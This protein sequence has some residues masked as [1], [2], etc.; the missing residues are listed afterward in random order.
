MI[1]VKQMTTVYSSG[2]GVFDVNFKVNKGEVIG[3]LGPNGAGKTTTIRSLLGFLKPKLGSALINDQNAWD[4]PTI[5]NKQIG[6]IPGEITFIDGMTGFEHLQLMLDLHKNNNK[7]RMNELLEKFEL[8]PQGK[9][10]RYSKGMK[11]K[12]ALV[13]AF[14]HDPD[15]LILDEPTSGLDPLMQKRFIDLIKEEK[16]KGKTI[17]ISSHQFEEVEKTC[18][19]VI[20]IK[21]GKIIE[22][23]DKK[24]L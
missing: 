13:S 20:I 8:N 10:R 9:I 21:E 17:L 18:D 22:I 5:T 12:L 2:K 4:N 19:E 15:I 6:Y 7:E 24:R 14:M 3:F 1:E 11:Q 23:L 16:A